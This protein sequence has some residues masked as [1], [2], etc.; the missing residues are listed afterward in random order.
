[1]R[2][3]IRPSILAIAQQEQNRNSASLVRAR[4]VRIVQPVGKRLIPF[5]A[6]NMFYRGEPEST[7]LAPLRQPAIAAVN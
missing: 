5:D 7:R 2:P 3:E 1:V 4:K 6:F